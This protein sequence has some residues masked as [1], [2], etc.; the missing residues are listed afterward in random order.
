MPAASLISVVPR[1]VSKEEH[2]SL[3]ASTPS[4]FND[5]PPVLE[6]RE[7]N[8]SVALDPPLE[9]FTEQDAVQGTLYVISSVL[10]FMS[11]TG[12][13]FQIEYPSITLH[14]ISRA[15]PRPSIYC[16]LDEG[17]SAA[18]EQHMNGDVNEG[19][20]EEQEEYADMRELNIIPQNPEALEHIFE[21]L[22]QCASQHPDAS[23]DSDEE[24]TFI[25]PG[26]AEFEVF[27]GDEGE[28][29]SEVGRTYFLS[30][31]LFERALNQVALAHLESI[32]Y[33][34][35]EP[36]QK[37]NGVHD[38]VDSDHE[39]GQPHSLQTSEQTSGSAERQH[40]TQQ[41]DP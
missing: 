30:P 9:G 15:G 16:Q 5:L 38:E 2:R 36:S 11:T 19:G 33:N 34:P 20:N 17:T 3:I 29:L 31:S 32:I 14:A 35:F 41:C 8:V 23:G 26:N 1:F 6:H 22:S 21:A 4:S 24:D 25:D 18:Q 7:D 40:E 27:N 39:E 10:V 13:G 12:R 28:E 37:S